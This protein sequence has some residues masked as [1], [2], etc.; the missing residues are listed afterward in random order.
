MQKARMWKNIDLLIITKQQ[1]SS[2]YSFLIFLKQFNNKK[3]I[4]ID[5][6]FSTEIC[7]VAGKLFSLY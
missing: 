3:T 2:M 6:S 4:E 5:S 7:I 1:I